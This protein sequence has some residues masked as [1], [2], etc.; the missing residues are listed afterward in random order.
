MN[1]QRIL[2]VTQN[3]DRNIIGAIDK[4]DFIVLIV[5]KASSMS[6]D[7]VTALSGKAFGIVQV[8]NTDDDMNIAYALG[9]IAQNAHDIGDFVEFAPDVPKKYVNFFLKITEGMF[10]TEQSNKAK[11]KPAKTGRAK[12]SDKP[13]ST[14]PAPADA[15]DT[16][17]AEL[18]SADKAEPAPTPEPAPKAEPT[19][20]PMAEAMN[21][22]FADTADS[23]SVF[24]ESEIKKLAK[25]IV[26]D[27]GVDTKYTNGIEAALGKVKDMSTLKTLLQMELSVANVTSS[28]LDK[29]YSIAMDKSI[30]VLGEE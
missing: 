17:K 4:D 8:L 15:T 28:D 9:R 22:P 25:Q 7:L 27:A 1:K 13:D 24:T 6:M 19:K 26:A 30:D 23:K 16:T 11:P 3:T 18:E 2:I 20:D 5:K 21:P 14:V 10:T 29:I 12:K